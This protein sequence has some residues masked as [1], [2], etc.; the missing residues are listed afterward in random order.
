MGRERWELVSK[1]KITHEAHEKT[2]DYLFKYIFKKP[3]D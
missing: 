3:N 1:E 2:G